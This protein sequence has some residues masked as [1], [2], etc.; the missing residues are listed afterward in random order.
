MENKNQQLKTRVSSLRSLQ[1][2][3]M[4]CYNINFEI[5][6]KTELHSKSYHVPTENLQISV[7]KSQLLTFL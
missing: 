2:N 4:V 5:N 6:D 3:G 1:P 7:N